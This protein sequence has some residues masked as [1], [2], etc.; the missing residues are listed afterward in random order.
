M[1]IIVGNSQARQHRHYREQRGCFRLPGG[2]STVVPTNGGRRNLLHS[3]AFVAGSAAGPGQF[4]NAGVCNSGH[5][6]RAAWQKKRTEAGSLSSLPQGA[7]KGRRAPTRD[8]GCPQG[9]QGAH[10]GRGRPQGMPQRYF[11]VGGRVSGPRVGRAGG[12]AT[13]LN[14]VED[15]TDVRAF[16][17]RWRICQSGADWWGE[18]TQAWGRGWACAGQGRVRAMARA[19]RESDGFFGV[20][21]ASGAGCGRGWATGV[22]A[23]A[24]EGHWLRAY[25]TTKSS[26]PS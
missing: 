12:F 22:C 23:G 5:K 7:H 21:G 3:V 15:S 20:P 2:P 17:D 10:K 1:S 8:A 14:R 18:M 4:C 26:P 11:P 24:S 13:R 19:E 9:T 16:Q 6:C 25:Q